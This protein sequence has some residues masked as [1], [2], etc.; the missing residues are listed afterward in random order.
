[1]VR[2]D[3][4]GDAALLAKFDQRRES[5]ADPIQLGRVLFVGV[6]TNNEFLRV[7]VVARIDPDFV[8]PVGRFHRRFRFEMNIGHDRHIAAALTQSLDDIFQIARVFH[9]RGGYP[10]NLTTDIRQFDRLLDRHLRV[11][12]VAR[13]HRLDPNRII[14]ADADIANADFARRTPTIVQWILAITHSLGW[15]GL[16]HYGCAV[17]QNFR[18]TLH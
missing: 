3:S 14:P 8:D 7:G 11:H 2:S 4:H 17:T 12:R 18:Y 5:L 16:D 10:H 13:A 1:M 9:R 6:F 15:V